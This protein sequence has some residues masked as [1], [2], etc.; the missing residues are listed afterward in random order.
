MYSPRPSEI[1]LATQREVITS[2]DY[3]MCP[4]FRSNNAINTMIVVKS[5]GNLHSI[6]AG[7]IHSHNNH[8]EPDENRTLGV[9]LQ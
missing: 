6:K 1:D 5:D 8:Y 3:G 2:C 4:T 7:R 9:L